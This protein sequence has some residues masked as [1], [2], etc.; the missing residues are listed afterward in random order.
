MSF[1]MKLFLP[2]AI[3]I[4]KSTVKK[5]TPELRQEVVDFILEWEKKCLATANKWDDVVVVA[6]KGV[7]NIK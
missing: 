1:V 6:I 3:R 5:M 7:L 2:I 4:I